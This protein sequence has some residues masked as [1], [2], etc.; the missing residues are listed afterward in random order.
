MGNGEGERVWGVVNHPGWAPPGSELKGV[1]YRALVMELP[2]LLEREAVEMVVGGDGEVDPGVVVRPP[3]VTLRAWLENMVAMELAPR[4]ESE[5][6]VALY[7]RARFRVRGKGIE[8]GEFRALMKALKALRGG[9]RGNP[10]VPAQPE[11]EQGEW[12]YLGGDGEYE[13]SV[14]VDRDRSSR[15]HFFGAGAR[16]GGYE[17]TSNDDFGF[18]SY[19][20]GGSVSGEY[21]PDRPD[22]GSSYVPPVARTTSGATT[23]ITQPG[24]RSGYASS[25]VAGSS[26]IRGGGDDMDSISIEF[27]RSGRRQLSVRVPSGTFG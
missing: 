23:I 7:E 4:E 18:V 9:M 25:S 11:T 8:E 3:Q 20:A 19:V 26:V 21:I 22:T 27:D 15:G 12:E 1:E 13:G 6:F 16:Y 5:V 14:R 2:A 24:R 10:P 17:T